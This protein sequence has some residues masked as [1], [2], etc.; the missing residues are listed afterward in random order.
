MEFR[1]SSELSVGEIKLFVN[2][3]ILPFMDVWEAVERKVSYPK[4]CKYSYPIPTAADMKFYTRPFRQGS[5]KADFLNKYANELQQHGLIEDCD[6]RTCISQAMATHKADAAPGIFR[7]VTDYRKV[8]EFTV[9]DHMGLPFIWDLAY[10]L[11]GCKWITELD[12]AS[13]YWQIGVMKKDRYKTAFKVPDG[14]V[15]V[16]T[17]VGNL[18]DHLRDLEKVLLACREHGLTLKPKKSYLAMD[19]L[20]VVGLIVSEKGVRVN[21]ERLQAIRDFKFPLSK[22]AV[23]RVLGMANQFRDHIFKYSVIV[24]EL[25]KLTR[26][27]WPNKWTMDVVPPDAV[28]ALENLKSALMSQPI[29]AKPRRGC[30]YAL[31]VDASDTG[32]AA[33]LCQMQDEV[34]KLIACISRSLTDPETRYATHHKEGLAVIWALQRFK[35]Y[36]CNAP[37][38][39]YTDHRNLVWLLRLSGSQKGRLGRWATMMAEWR[40]LTVTPTE[41][42]DVELMA[43]N[44]RILCH[45]P[46]KNIPAADCLSRQ[47]DLEDGGSRCES[48]NNV[49]LSLTVDKKS[50]EPVYRMPT[51]EQIREAQKDDP[52]CRHIRKDPRLGLDDGDHVYFERNGIVCHRIRRFNSVLS[53]VL[54]PATLQVQLTK[55]IHHA[56]VGGLLGRAKTFDMMMRLGFYFPNMRTVIRKVLQQSRENQ[57]AKAHRNNLNVSRGLSPFEYQKW[58]RISVD[59]VSP[60]TADRLG[61]TSLLVV[62]D[63]CTKYAIT[64]PVKSQGEIATADALFYH[65][66]MTHG[67]PEMLLSDKGAAFMSAVV[68]RLLRLCQMGRSQDRRVLDLF[69]QDRR[70]VA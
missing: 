67:F 59:H 49:I 2:C 11:A 17:R 50:K 4:Q 65:V 14:R 28:V 18:M 66:F 68:T 60:Y 22:T 3:V 35:T 70:D 69:S 34:E 9:D 40:I 5:A 37:F 33:R 41:A 38:T 47:Y 54:V 63:I 44:S 46:G 53:Q 45:R 42:N 12:L 24:A 15:F 39:I 62:M 36:L 55:A 20:N 52:T 51:L 30:P 16:Y 48:T 27:T 64:I 25:T 6:R 13:G 57:L 8:N 61:R 1:L 23:R 43:R 26:K 7:F 32:I 10:E 58:R 31:E 29:L 19:E 21:P 56:H